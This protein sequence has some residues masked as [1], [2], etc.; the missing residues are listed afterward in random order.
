MGL[1]TW[2]TFTLTKLRCFDAHCESKLM[3][4]QRRKNVVFV[5]VSL[6]MCFGC[7]HVF[8]LAAA[9]CRGAQAGEPGQSTHSPI[10]HHCFSSFQF[11]TGVSL[12]VDRLLPCCLYI[13]H[14]Q[15]DLYVWLCLLNKFEL[16]FFPSRWSFKISHLCPSI[17]CCHYSKGFLEPVPAVVWQ[18]QGDTRDKSVNKI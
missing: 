3:A 18:R 15:I 14:P 5:F 1:F 11:L 2:A 7:G 13:I 8:P 4:S 9:V 12:L 10:Q 6:G 16:F 17:T